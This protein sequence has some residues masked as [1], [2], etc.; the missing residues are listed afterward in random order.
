MKVTGREV[1]VWFLA[2][3]AWW[4]VTV[5]VI[6]PVFITPLYASIRSS[7][8]PAS[9]MVTIYTL[10]G[11]GVATVGWAIVLVLFLVCRGTGP[12]ANVQPPR[13]PNPILGPGR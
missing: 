5:F 7:G 8:V 6:F 2:H 3:L 4:A 10:V 1:V 12:D 13:L 11:L 9:Q